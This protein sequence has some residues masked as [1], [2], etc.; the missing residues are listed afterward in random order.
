M[1]KL[2]NSTNLLIPR[3]P[4]QRVVREIVQKYDSELRLQG[5]TIEALRE[6]SEM[7]LL[8]MFSDAYLCSHHAKRVTLQK[9]DIHLI[10]HIFPPTAYY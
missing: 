7:F 9:K 1:H 4:F 5:L 8:Q 6:S 2:Q 3:L 10:K